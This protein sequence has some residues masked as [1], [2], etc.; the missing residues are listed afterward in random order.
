MWG[1]GTAFTAAWLVLGQPPLA[2]WFFWV[3]FLAL[4]PPK[5]LVESFE[6]DV[7]D[8]YLRQLLPI[9]NGTL[10]LAGGI[11]PLAVA[12]AGV[13]LGWTLSFARFGLGTEGWA[14]GLAIGLAGVLIVLLAQAAAAAHVGLFGW[15]PPYAAWLIASIA[16]VGGSI[17]AFGMLPGAI[18]GCILALG[19]LGLMVAAS[20]PIVYD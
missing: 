18:A 14:F 4:V 12:V 10:A 17:F 5:M 15:R 16:I 3:T 1:V 19:L 13:W 8:P 2:L 7:A 9:S 20:Q 6:A 11:V